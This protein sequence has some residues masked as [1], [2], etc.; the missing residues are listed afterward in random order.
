MDHYN[1]DEV[2]CSKFEDVF[3]HIFKYLDVQ[4]LMNCR[5]VSC[6]WYQIITSNETIFKQALLNEAV[7]N[8]LEDWKK[9]NRILNLEELQKLCVF[10]SQV[11]KRVENYGKSPF[12][13]F[14]RMNDTDLFNKAWPILKNSEFFHDQIDG[15]M[16]PIFLMRV[17]DDLETF[18]K[19][20]E[21]LNQE[22]GNSGWFQQ[23]FELNTAVLLNRSK[24]VDY[25]VKNGS[26]NFL[27]ISTFDDLN[28][29]S[30]H[31]SIRRMPGMNNLH[32]YAIQGNIIKFEDTFLSV[33]PFE[34]RNARSANILDCSPLQFATWKGRF[35]ICQYII[36]NV[37]DLD[38]KVLEES[39]I[40]SIRYGHEKIFDLF[41]DK[42][43]N[44]NPKPM[45]SS[46]LHIA[47][48]YNRQRMFDK[49]F[50]TVDSV[51]GK[52]AFGYDPVFHTAQR[53]DTK[54]TRMIMDKLFKTIDNSSIPKK[55]LKKMFKDA[56]AIAVDNCHFKMA[57]Y[58]AE[59][60]EKIVE[61]AE[62]LP[63]GA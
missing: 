41:Y 48:K 1:L 18:S 12:F 63:T 60:L 16:I 21:F 51:Y 36:E 28:L 22:N 30:R 44:K 46:A 37:Q 62:K 59:T 32:L 24:I 8:S 35:T 27:N 50:E 2:F 54:M 34:D 49:I 3:V 52:D 53:G 57:D 20:Y 55:E 40:A 42:L 38:V 29:Y 25:L 10:K 11:D 45:G 39:Y 9:L 26:I 33:F 17:T 7:E 5:L 47:A 43:D 23:A 58:I 13:Y 4:S 15:V 61:K 31:R 56:C 14:A 6:S 19:M